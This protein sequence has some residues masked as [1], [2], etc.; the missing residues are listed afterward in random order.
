MEEHQIEVG[1]LANIQKLGDQWKVIHDLK[2]T[3]YLSAGFVN[4]CTF[5]LSLQSGSYFIAFS[6]ERGSV[7]LGSYTHLYKEED[8]MVE[9]MHLPQ[10]G[11]WTRFELSREFDE[12]AGKYV[13]SF[14]V[15][16]VEVGKAEDENILY[17]QPED[18]RIY[19]PDEDGE[20]SGFIRRIVVLEK[21]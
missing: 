5:A 20:I 2:P 18:A 16:G 11:K 15:G 3:A 19:N 8:I 6:L 10:E 1:T 9:S 21:S 17:V 14:S 12:N 13:I 7:G 4:T